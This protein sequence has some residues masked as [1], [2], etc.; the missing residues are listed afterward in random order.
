LGR[1]LNPKRISNAELQV[2]FIFKNKKRLKIFLKLKL[3]ATFLSRI[4]MDDLNKALNYYLNDTK[5]NNISLIDEISTKYN[6][7]NEFDSFYQDAYSS[8]VT[9]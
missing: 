6:T 3:R 8:A 5:Q 9:H 1:F 7:C 4:G 2:S